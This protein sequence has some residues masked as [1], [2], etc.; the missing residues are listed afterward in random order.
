MVWDMCEL[1]ITGRFD[2]IVIVAGSAT[3]TN[4]VSRVRRK[5]VDVKIVF[6][7]ENCDPA[8]K[9]KGTAFRHINL[10]AVNLRK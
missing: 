5:G 6:F 2:T 7:D 4:I 3:F 10:D 9:S 8:L 1:I